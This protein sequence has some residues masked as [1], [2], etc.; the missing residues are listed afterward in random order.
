[1]L[2]N[3]ETL[4]KPRRNELLVACML[5]VDLALLWH[6]P[7]SYDTTD[8]FSVFN[9][10]SKAMVLNPDFTLERSGEL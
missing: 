10:F 1:M 8:V 5:H 7:L 3:F 4:I 6:H 9:V 2:N